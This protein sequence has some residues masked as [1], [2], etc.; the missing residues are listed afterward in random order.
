[1]LDSL[2]NNLAYLTFTKLK[3]KL[4]FSSFSFSIVLSDENVLEG[5]VFDVF[6]CP[7]LNFGCVTFCVMKPT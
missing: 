7:A 5:P 1:M 2:E 6:E 3:T 4:K